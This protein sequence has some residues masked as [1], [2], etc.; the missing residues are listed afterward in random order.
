MDLTSYYIG[1][2]WGIAV[3]YIFYKISQYGR[4]SAKPMAC[5]LFFEIVKK[6]ENVIIFITAMSLRMWHFF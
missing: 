6:Q 5:H 3:S 4:Y 1:L 2:V